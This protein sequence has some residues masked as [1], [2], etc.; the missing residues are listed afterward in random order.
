MFADSPSDELS[1]IIKKLPLDCQQSIQC[2]EVKVLPPV[3][4]EPLLMR[5]QPGEHAEVDVGIM[6]RDIDIGVMEDGMLPVPEIRTAAKHI[7]RSRHQLV[8]TE[9]GRVSS[10]TGVVLCVW[11]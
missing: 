7:H 1:K 8:D 5:R 3:K 9:L 10:V 11:S 6:A 4:H 2:P